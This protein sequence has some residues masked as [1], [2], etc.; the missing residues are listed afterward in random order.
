[1]SH[2]K[3]VGQTVEID[4][5]DGYLPNDNG[6]FVVPAKISGKFVV[7]EF[8]PY[9]PS[10]YHFEAGHLLYSPEQD[11]EAFIPLEEIE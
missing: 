9:E 7:E 4:N 8:W 1:M 10:A 3:I 2:S 11:T 5:V 6:D